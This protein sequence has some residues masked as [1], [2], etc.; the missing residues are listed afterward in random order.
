MIATNNYG[1]CIVIGNL[2]I[3]GGWFNNNT[4]SDRTITFPKKFPN[5]V[6]IISSTGNW[7]RITVSL[8]KFSIMDTHWGSDKPPYIGWIAIGY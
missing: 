4:W 7:G 1:N 3:Q 6:A 8:D 5:K 2:Y